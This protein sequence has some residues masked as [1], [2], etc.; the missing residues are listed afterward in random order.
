MTTESPT[1]PST[2][3]T[4]LPIFSHWIDGGPVELAATQ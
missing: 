4:I 1:R 2:S 3:P